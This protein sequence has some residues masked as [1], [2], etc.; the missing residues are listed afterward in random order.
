[1]TSNP[2]QISGLGATVQVRDNTDVVHTGIIK[3]LNTMASGNKVISGCDITQQAS[4]GGSSA[5]TTQ[6]SVANGQYL[7]DKSSRNTSTTCF[8]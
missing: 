3:A 7:Q 8:K 6:F 2:K 5:A 1:M 4:T